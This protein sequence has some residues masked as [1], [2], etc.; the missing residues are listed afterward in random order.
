MYNLL[1]YSDN[2]ADSSGSLWQYKRDEQNMTAAGNP[3]NINT[4]DSSSF[5]YKSIF[6]EDLASR[7]AAA[8]TN[9]D[10]PD[11]HRLFTNAKIVV[12]LKYLSTFFR[13]LEMPL[14]N[15]KINFKLNWTKNCVMSS[16]VG[17]T[18]FQITSTKLYVPIVTL[19][20]KNSVRLTKQLDSRFKRSV[21]WN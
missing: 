13:S 2:Y 9:P 17:A 1:E 20:T 4:N 21:F 19:S 16:V 10:T 11:A 6:L 7:N 12:A 8:N 15:C 3:D 18:I 14:I 5:K